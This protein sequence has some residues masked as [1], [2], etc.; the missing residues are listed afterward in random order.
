MTAKSPHPAARLPWLALLVGALLLAYPLIRLAPLVRSQLGLRDAARPTYSASFGSPTELGRSQRFRVLAPRAYIADTEVSALLQQAEERRTRLM[1]ELGL[2]D[3][4][5]QVTITLRPEIGVPI[6]T[7]RTVVLYAYQLGRGDFVHE[8]THV[9]TGY[10]SAFLAEGLAVRME[11]RLGWGVA[12]ATSG[13]PLSAHVSAALCSGDLPAIADLLRRK[14]L[15]DPGDVYASRLRYAVAGS[16]TG[17]LIDTYGLPAW[18]ALYGNANVQMDFEGMYGRSLAA[19]EQEWRAVVGRTAAL[20]AAWLIVLGAATAAVIYRGA[21]C[22]GAWLG[23]AAVTALA[24]AA[25]SYYLV[26]GWAAFAAPAAWLLAAF[27]SHRLRRTAAG[28]TS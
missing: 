21:R 17:Y 14:S 5:R 15:W 27:L 7:G 9:L 28:R 26:W 18:L 25:W 22:G 13:R 6:G 4:D 19:L 10:N 23:S 1:A 8:L 2:P 12:F 24:H 11:Q 20:Q 16:F 3:D